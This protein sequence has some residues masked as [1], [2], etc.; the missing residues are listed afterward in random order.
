MKWT[1]KAW[2]KGD[3]QIVTRF[4]LFPLCLAG[5]CRWWEKVKVKQQLQERYIGEGDWKYE[6]HD[7]E[8]AN[9]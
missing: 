7:L 6:W 9:E 1:P 2:N 4:L 5:E 3:I 8:F